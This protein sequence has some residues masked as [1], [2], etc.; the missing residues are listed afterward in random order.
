MN[1]LRR[2]GQSVEEDVPATPDE[3]T[4]LRKPPNTA[5]RQQRLKAWQPLLTPK[6]VIPLLVLLAVVFIPLGLVLVYYSSRVQN[7]IVDYSKCGTLGGAD[8]S[9]VPAKYFSY[10]YH[11]SN[12]DINETPQWLVSNATDSFGDVISTC[13][14]KFDLP[15]DIEPPFFLYYKLTN[16]YQN[17]R[18]YVQ[19]FDLSQLKGEAVSMGSLTDHCKPLKNSSDGKI[20]YPCGLIANSLF[21]DTFSHLTLLNPA[22]GESNMTYT[23]SRNGISWSSDR[24]SKFKK[25]T[26]NASQIAPP[27]NW[28]KRF[29][30]GYTEENLPNLAHWEHLQNWMRTAGLP[31]FYKLYSRNTTATLSS[32]T[33][34]VDIEMN[35]PVSIFG[36]TKSIVIT[37]SSIIGGR[38]LSLGIVYIVVG[39][40]SLV[41]AIGFMVQH[42][43]KPRKLGD[44]S[45]Y[46]AG[47]NVREQL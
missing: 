41:C 3:R 9:V 17:H 31:S 30:E 40:L 4:K 11:K 38:N 16:F 45:S 37:T 27:P 42:L 10:N 15:N 1:F 19:S 8:Y 29:P 18:S 44:P 23:M 5:F 24:H 33:Y 25:T 35:Y 28:Y 46:F 34:S 47:E 43:V 22:G 20:V 12:P 21:N 2:R 39:G 32:G 14:V 6:I 36:G 13:H 26:Y 7:L